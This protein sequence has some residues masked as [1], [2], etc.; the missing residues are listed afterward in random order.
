[1]K[2]ISKSIKI[3]EAIA[4]QQGVIYL[5]NQK[6]RTQLFDL[7]REFLQRIE[8]SLSFDRGEQL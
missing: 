7:G 6:I 2:V 4:E 8:P 1:M 5:N 3:E